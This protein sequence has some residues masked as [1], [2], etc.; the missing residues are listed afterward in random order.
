M[1]HFS[2]CRLPGVLSVAFLSLV[3]SLCTTAIEA[4]EVV[5]VVA[6]E[7]PPYLFQTAEGPAGLEADIL[8]YVA[9]TTGWQ[10]EY[11]FVT[12]WAAVFDALETREADLVAASMT[13]T[14]ERL[15]R[16]DFSSSYMPVVV[17]LVERAGEES[18]SLDDLRGARLAVIPN[19]TPEE[20]LAEVPGRVFVYGESEPQLIQWVAE[21]KADAAAIDSTLAHPLLHDYPTLRLTL[22]LGEPEQYGFAMPKGSPLKAELDEAVGLLRS[23]RIYYRLLEKHL[24]SDAVR[25]MR[26]AKRERATTD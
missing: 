18:E 8:S 13:I 11:R 4:Q 15:A 3:S 19:S 6:C 12:P 5:R 9:Q 26:L 22:P 17:M 10:L 7:S 24:G 21:G 25:V 16:F 14:A 20:K 1:A 23:S 2:T